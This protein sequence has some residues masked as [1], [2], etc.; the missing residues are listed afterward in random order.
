MNNNKNLL[1]YHIL[2]LLVN[3]F[4]LKLVLADPLNILCSSVCSFSENITDIY[5]WIIFLLILWLLMIIQII[6]LIK[7]FNSMTKK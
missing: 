7:S 4:F 6:E 5:M 3:L 1:F 2:G